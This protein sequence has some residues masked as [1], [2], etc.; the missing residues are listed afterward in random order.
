M[1]FTKEMTIKEAL[2]VDSRSAEVFQSF[3]MHC[4]YCPAASGE[5]IVEAAEVH[6]IN[7]EELM[8]KLNAL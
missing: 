1:K 5:P 7:V 4:L 2:A 6:G 8:E 3:G